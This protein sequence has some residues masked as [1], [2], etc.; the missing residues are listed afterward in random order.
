MAAQLTSSAELSLRT[1][2]IKKFSIEISNLEDRFSF[3]FAAN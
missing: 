3:T 1:L 2:R